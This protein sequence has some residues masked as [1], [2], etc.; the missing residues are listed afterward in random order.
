MERVLEVIRLGDPPPLGSAHLERACSL[1][2]GTVQGE[3]DPRRSRH[4]R[5][6]SRRI[7]GARSP[8]RGGDPKGGSPGSGSVSQPSLRPP[9]RAPGQ[10][11]R[12]EH[13]GFRFQLLFGA[14]QVRG[15]RHPSGRSIRGDLS[16]SPRH[17]RPVLG[18]RALVVLDA[19]RRLG[20]DGVIDHYHTG[21]RYMAA[22]TLAL[23]QA[24]TRELGIP[25][26]AFEW[27]NFD[28]R[29]YNERELVGKL[30][31]FAGMMDAA[32]ARPAVEG[33]LQ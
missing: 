16:A 1:C 21:C 18:G 30:E 6:S 15:G 11:T 24:I 14:G 10:Q 3:R 17:A 32:D 12:P 8:G 25:V 7:A 20:I 5:Y 33:A 23:R 22:D 13:R 19:C 9:I 31:T 28:P 4:L 26:L 29:C 2:A 27:D